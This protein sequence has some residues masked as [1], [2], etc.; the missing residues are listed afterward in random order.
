MEK[1][2]QFLEELA[3]NNNR[4][5]FNANRD[6]Y[7]ECRGKI[8][9]VT[10]ILINE[11]SKFDPDVTIMNPK[12]CMFRIFRDVRFSN[13]K[14]PYKTNFGSFIARG[15]RK[16]DR[17]GYYFHVEPGGSF[18]GGGVYH[19]AAAPLK[20]IRLHIDK[21]P[22]EFVQIIEDKEFKSVFPEMYDDKLQTAPKGFA[23][24]H[25]YINLL[26]YKSF[27]F[28]TDVDK[29]NLTFENFLEYAANAYKQLAKVNLFL[30][31]ALDMYQEKK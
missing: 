3:A 16:S 28:S 26:R 15:G 8:L 31:E 23:K 9:F 13:D 7:E 6:R 17:A 11:I 10:E 20:A 1:V 4:D 5:W 21:H 25:E 14:R 2:L 30:N 27:V 12:D 22:D 29:K 19:P 18:I 24:D